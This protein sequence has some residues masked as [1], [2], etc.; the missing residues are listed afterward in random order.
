VRL[1]FLDNFVSYGT[2]VLKQR[3]S[4]YPNLEVL[5]ANPLM[6]VV[7]PLDGYVALALLMGPLTNTG[8]FGMFILFG[9]RSISY[10]FPQGDII[11]QNASIEVLTRTQA[12]PSF[13]SDTI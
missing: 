5:I 2:D 4:N 1:L 9:R 8:M 3:C 11:A 12:K 10:L 6:A 7:G 13:I